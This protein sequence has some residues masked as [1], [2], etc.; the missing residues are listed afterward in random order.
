MLTKH[1][2]MGKAEI[3]IRNLDEIGQAASEFLPY[4]NYSKVVAFY[5]EMGAGK[6]TF[7]KALCGCLG[8][9]DTVNSPTFAIINE[10]FTAKRDLIYHLDLYR[11]RKPEEL[12][13]I[14]YEDY[15]L[16]GNYLFIEWP[17]KAEDLLPSDCIVVNISRENDESRKLRIEFSGN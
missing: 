2:N 4:L 12:L 13:D 15:L 7:I 17:E 1:K 9:T 3:V 8:V 5:G 6:T 11:L 14:G 16:S 10:Y